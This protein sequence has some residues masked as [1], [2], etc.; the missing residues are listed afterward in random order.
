M[1]ALTWARPAR[2]VRAQARAVLGRDFV[3]A[4]RSAGTPLLALLGRHVLPHTWPLVLAQAVIT[5]SQALAL[6][7]AISFLGLGDPATKS[8]GA[9]LYYAQARNAPLTG[10]WLW[11]VVPPGL[12]ITLAVLGTALAGLRVE[13][14]RT[15]R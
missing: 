3:L 6:E 15:Q 13:H 4:A 1:A 7:A 8:W 10:A 5:A 2:L 14:G 9:M 12:M 11:W